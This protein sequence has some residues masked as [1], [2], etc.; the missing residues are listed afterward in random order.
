MMLD[1]LHRSRMQFPGMALGF[2]Q[3]LEDEAVSHCRQRQVGGK[4]LFSYD[5]VQQRLATLQANVT[6]ATAMC[7][8]SSKKAGTRN[9]LSGAGLEA[10]A[11]KT[12]VTDLMQDSAQSLLQLVG[13]KGYRL[14]HIAGRALID[15]RPFQ[16]FE[17]S[18][19]I[20]YIQIAE[21]IQK[22]M[23]RRKI[24]NLLAFVSVFELTSRTAA[25][26]KVHLNIDL[27]L[28]LSQRR[29]NAFGQLISRIIALQL[30]EELGDSGYH[31]VLIA[32][33]RE[34]LIQR[35]AA[36]VSGFRA[37]GSNN[38]HEVDKHSGWLDCFY[39]QENRNR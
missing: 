36:E 39:Q 28:P 25:Y 5:Q 32:N 6:I 26:L 14:D 29:L 34:Q 30:V 9:D 11:V 20:L 22:L 27:I 18:N 23:H 10:N 4:N 8:N 19:D 31:P 21:A 24:N 33:C 13:A 1:L 38:Y 2:L 7:L 3:R 12:V 15:S 35:I 17:G 37:L 16:I